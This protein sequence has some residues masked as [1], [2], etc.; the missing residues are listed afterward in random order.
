[1][2][3]NPLIA[4]G[5]PGKSRKVRHRDGMTPEKWAVLEREADLR[6]KMTR[7]KVLAA[8]LGLT[9]LYVCRALA[10]LVQERRGL[11][12]RLAHVFALDKDDPLRQLRCSE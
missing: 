7:N 4:L 2:S 9:E 8:Q 6:V 12:P 11:V 10:R 3:L 5:F 1:M